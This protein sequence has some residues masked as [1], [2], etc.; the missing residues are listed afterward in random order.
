[1]SVLDGDVTRRAF[2]QY[3]SAAMG[4]FVA[5]KG[6]KAM[7]EE[8]NEGGD[9]ALLKKLRTPHKFPEL[10]LKASYQKGKFD[11]LAVD[12]PFVFRHKRRFYMTYVGFDGVGYRTGLA[13]S[14]DLVKWEKEGLLLDR[15][16]KGSVTEFNVAMSWLLRDND[17]FGEGRLSK[18]DGKFVG[19]YHAYPNPGYEEGPACIG[20]CIGDDF[21]KMKLKD[22]CLFAS[23][24]DAGEWEQGG[25]Y[26]SCLLE[27]DGVYYMFYNAKNK[28]QPWVEQTGVATSKDLKKW[29]RFAG[30][31]IISIGAKGR[32]DDIFC[33]DPCVLKVG[34]A[35]AMFYYTLSSDGRARD[36][37]AFS[38][39]LLHWRKSDEILIDVGAPGSIDSMFA[40]KPSVFAEGGRLH[41]YYCAVSPATQKTMGDVDVSEIRGIGL[42]TY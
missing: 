40:H 8:R 14:G 22:P 23:D 30:N 42:A 17:L 33:S 38:N 16:P 7:G 12:C 34:D 32:F 20:I 10:V 35:W 25:L 2:L 27:H 1:M 21:R 31:P 39:D 15:G 19:T 28:G 24:S 26:K 11:S 36:T 6:V 5:I 29:K 18:A 4:A 37:V 41:H 13:S 3:G 9:G